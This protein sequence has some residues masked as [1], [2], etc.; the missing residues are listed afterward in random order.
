MSDRTL[1]THCS[2]TLAGMKTG[3]LF[4]CRYSS[5]DQLYGFA[6]KWNEELNP[7]G[8]H[9]RVMR[10]CN[11]M[12]LIYVYRKIKLEKELQDSKVKSFMENRG[13]NCRD[14][15][16]MLNLL[17]E[18]LQKNGGF[19]HEI[20]VFLGYPFEDVREFITN[21]GRNYKLVGH[22]KVYCNEHAARQMFNKYDK[23]TDVYRKKLD[24]GAKLCRLTVKDNLICP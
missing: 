12:A 21:K 17:V 3:N 24:D 8:V 22:W 14:I 5:S 13:Y 11:G 15:G 2:P 18:R 16:E 20:G 4:S 9:V 10:A 1:I 19:P 6:V 23:C 7:R